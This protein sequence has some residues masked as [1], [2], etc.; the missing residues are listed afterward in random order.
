MNLPYPER[1]E[2]IDLTKARLAKVRLYVAPAR[3]CNTNRGTD[4]CNAWLRLVDQLASSWKI[5]Q[6]SLIAAANRPPIDY[7]VQRRN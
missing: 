5:R 1:M 7:D 6:A 4:D 2:L 3:P